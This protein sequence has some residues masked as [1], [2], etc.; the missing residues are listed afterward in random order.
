MHRWLTGI[1]M[2][3]WLATA[4]IA[5][6]DEALCDCDAECTGR[7]DPLAGQV[8]EDE[9]HRL[10]YEVRFW[11][12]ACHSGLWWCWTGPSWYDLMADVLSRVA[13]AE[14][15]QMCPRLYA[16][17]IRMGHEWARDNAIRRIH[18]EDLKSWRAFLRETQ[19]PGTTLAQ[20]E[21]LVADRLK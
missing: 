2:V 19:D 14:Q 18:T 21:T 9:T 20:I 17:G 15:A 4:S 13:A 12:G 16:L 3:A 5:S 1:G 8:Y 10:W 7:A 6:A 11:T